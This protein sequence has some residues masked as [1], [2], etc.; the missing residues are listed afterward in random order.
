MTE[1]AEKMLILL[2][3]GWLVITRATAST[4]R[5]KKHMTMLV[6]V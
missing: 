6:D 4:N 5:A 1:W 3:P 2:S